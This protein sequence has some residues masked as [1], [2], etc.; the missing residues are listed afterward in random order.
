[1]GR[2]SM[3]T[4]LIGLG[5]RLVGLGLIWVGDGSDNL[6]RKLLVVLGVVLTV[7]GIAVLRYLLLAKPLAQA[8]AAI[9]RR[10]SGHRE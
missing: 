3:K 9:R 1:M 2:A 7:G 6:F 5:I 4:L 8:E 10:W